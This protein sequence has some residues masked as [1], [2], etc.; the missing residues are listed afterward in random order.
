MLISDS[1]IL[2]VRKFTLADMKPR[3]MELVNGVAGPAQV[4]ELIHIPDVHALPLGPVYVAQ[5]FL[6]MVIHMGQP[7]IMKSP[8]L[9][10][11]FVTIVWNSYVTHSSD[12]FQMTHLHG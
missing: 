2:V 1:A 10:A 9:D 7:F 11:P 4:V 12:K 3:I 6:R 5:Q 8:I